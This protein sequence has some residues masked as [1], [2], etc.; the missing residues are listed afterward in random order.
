MK[1][2]RKLSTI[3]ARMLRPSAAH[4]L[5]ERL[6][7]QKCTELELLPGIRAARIG[8]ET[9]RLKQ[10]SSEPTGS[11]G[12]TPESY[13]LEFE[14]CSTDAERLNVLGKLQRHIN[15]ARGGSLLAE[16]RGTPEWKRAI[17]TDTRAS[18][19]VAVEYGISASRVRQL[20]ME[21]VLLGEGDS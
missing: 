20:R 2:R 15:A 8:S 21:H 18:A 7:R 6:L 16:R 14:E 5:L 17:A 10:G 19:V 9:A 12:R 1:R 3:T 11:G 13:R 4:P